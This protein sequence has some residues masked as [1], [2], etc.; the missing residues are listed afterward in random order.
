MSI[1]T[2]AVL[3]VLFLAA[4]LCATPCQ[5]GD[6]PKAVARVGGAVISD[7]DVYY[8]METER[9]NGNGSITGAAALVSLVNDGLELEA[10]SRRGAAPTTEDIISFGRYVE[11]NAKSPKMLGKVKDVFGPDRESYERLYLA[12]KVVNMKLHRFYATDG[13]VHSGER[14]LIEKAHALVAGGKALRDAAGECGLGF[15]EFYFEDKDVTVGP[16]LQKFYTPE[17]DEMSEPLAAVLEKVKPGEVFGSI[18]EDDYAYR[19]IRLVMVK[20]ERFLVEA[21]TSEK[22]GFKELL[23][24]DA[25][26]TSVEILD[27]VLLDSVRSANPGIWWLKR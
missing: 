13:D 9:A 20:G 1:K 2:K 4:F 25:S 15:E 24:E 5:A 21:I 16:E 12:P 7:K 10:A 18:L 11:D 19:V 14:A 22:R 8:R 27:P 17:G 6:A 23:T 26:G 3:A